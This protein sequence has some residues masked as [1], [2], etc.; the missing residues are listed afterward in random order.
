MPTQANDNRPLSTDTVIEQRPSPEELNRILHRRFPGMG[1]AHGVQLDEA[2]RKTFNADFSKWLGLDGRWHPCGEYYR[3]PRG[4][5]RLAKPGTTAASSEPVR[6][7]WL[8]TDTVACRWREYALAT[9]DGALALVGK[10]VPA[11]RGRQLFVNEAEDRMIA[12]IDAVRETWAEIP[13][14][15]ARRGR[16]PKAAN[17]N[18]TLSRNVA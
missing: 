5:R 12:L 17:D 14:A 9:V 3:Q 6:D 4:S 13:A 8:F 18:N 7:G 15:P 2:A 10:T 11:V 1:P 16:P